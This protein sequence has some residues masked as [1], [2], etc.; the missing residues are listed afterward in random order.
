MVRPKEMTLPNGPSVFH[1]GKN[2]ALI[3][4]R[5][6]FDELVY[7]R[8]GI[9]IAEGD[10]VFDIGANIGLF[11]VYLAQQRFSSRS[12][13]CCDVAPTKSTRIQVR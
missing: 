12:R 5:E 4:Y 3:V 13:T 8:H 6:I 1:L 2:D 10:V 7:A 9:E 11:L